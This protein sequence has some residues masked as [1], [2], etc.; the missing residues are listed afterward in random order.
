MFYVFMYL[1]AIVA[2]NLTVAAFGPDWS[3]INAFLFIGLDL[4]ARDKLHDQWQGN[5]ARNMF[6]LIASG[7]A[8]SALLNIS[9]LQIAVAS[10]TAFVCAGVVDTIV[11]HMMKDRARLVRINGSNLFSA[12]ADSLI[13]PILAFGFPPLWGIVTG[14]FIA[15]GCGGFIWSMVF[16]VATVFVRRGNRTKNDS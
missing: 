4:T 10:T 16:Y 2:A 15:K 5:L 12:A 7:G 13:F 3:I 14:Q 6:L 1:A 11:Y 8:L 9:A